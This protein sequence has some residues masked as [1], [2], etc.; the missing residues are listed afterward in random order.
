MD[1]S[2]TLRRS[3]VYGA[4]VSFVI[5]IV[6]SVIGALAAGLPGLLSALIGSAVGFL[7]V[8]I[9]ALSVWLAARLTREDPGSPVFFVVI[10]GSWILKFVG[11]LALVLALRGLEALDPVVLFISL[12]AAAVGTVAGD[13]VAVLRSRVP[14][15]DPSLGGE[16]NDSSPE[17]SS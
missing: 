10:M 8:G 9:T 14:Y 17:A 12:V 1:V 7:F 15:T 4:A 2:Q 16:S 11:F 13:V 3:L 5:A 6:G